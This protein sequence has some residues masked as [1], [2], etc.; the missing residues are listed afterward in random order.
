M[1]IVKLGGSIITH[2]GVWREINIDNIK[3][4]AT[5]LKDADDQMILIHG[6]GSYGRAYLP[7]YDYDH[8]NIEQITMARH[9][10]NNLRNLNDIMVATLKKEGVN[11]RPF[12]PESTFRI[13]NGNIKDF[14]D[15]LMTWYLKNGYT[16]LIYGGTIWDD[17]DKYT[18]VSSDEIVYFFAMHYN[19]DQILW[20]TDVDGVYNINGEVIKYFNEKSMEDFYDSQYNDMD[21]TGGMRSKV[22]KSMKLLEYGITSYVING[23]KQDRLKNILNGKD[24][25]CTKFVRASSMKELVNV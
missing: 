10:Q 4:L 12:E 8:I 1:K 7:I 5:E 25:V 11:I 13:E 22:V 14:N 6:L 17:T 21:L 24:D 15:K 2:R 19:V 3:H 18:I 9:I 20:V 23:Y 16:P